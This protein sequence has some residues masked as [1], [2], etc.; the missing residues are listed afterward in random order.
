MLDTLELVRKQ[1]P[2]PPTRLQPKVPTDLETIC[3]KALQK[4][5]AKRF[6]T[7]AAMAEDLRR[8]LD[9][10]PI[11]ARPVGMHERLWRW[12]KRNPRVAVLSAV[13][14]L[15]GFA[16]TVGSV[17]A[18]AWLK[19]LNGELAESNK[20]E[21][22]ARELA[23]TKEKAAVG[24]RNE[25]IAA[26]KAEALARE[27][28]TKARE[29]AEALVEGAFAQNKN[30]LEAQRVLSVLLNQRLASI[31]GTQDLRD[32]MIR[33]TLSGLEATMASL[34]QLGTV[35]RDKEGFAL[36]TRTLA[37]INQHAGLIAMEYGKYDDTARYYRRMEELAE[38]LRRLTPRGSSPSK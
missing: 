27:K 20:K 25:A 26:T 3:L 23:Q 21:A 32:E 31:P 17:A 38:Q 9:N 1:E 36:A 18:V 16:I 13:V 10:E 8:F 37:G 35:A 15:M 11:V 24:A 33:T 7:V 6:P 12:C 22:L 28:E 30:A 29:K 5:P 2:V 14:A 19:S 34:E 4:D